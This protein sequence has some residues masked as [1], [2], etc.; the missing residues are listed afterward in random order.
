MD[1][2]EE[3]KVAIRMKVD[4]ENGGLIKKQENSKVI[5]SLMEGEEG[6]KVGERIKINSKRSHKTT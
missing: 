4:G 1:V 2:S 6:R 5:K 3:I